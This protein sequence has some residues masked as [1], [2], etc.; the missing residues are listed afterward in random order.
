MGNTW[1]ERER[2]FEERPVRTSLSLAA[3][4]GIVIGAVMVIGG[5]LGIAHWG[6]GV[7]T[8]DV[9]GQGDAIKVKNEAGNRIRAQEGFWIRYEG[10]L[11]ADKNIDITADQLRGDPTNG[12][13]KT[14]LAGQKMICNGLVGE[15]NAKA[16]GFRDEEFRDAELPHK[17]DDKDPTTDCKEN[18]K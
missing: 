13:L 10:I 6:F 18:N 14:E 2:N 8:S 3:R 7:F 17:I 15:Y 1:E 12:K 4:T 11:Q 16:S 9:K 5:G